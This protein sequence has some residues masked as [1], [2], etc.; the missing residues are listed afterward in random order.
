MDVHSPLP[1]ELFPTRP[2]VD[3][4]VEGLAGADAADTLLGYYSAG[5]RRADDH[6][7]A[8]LALLE[9]AGRLEETWVILTADHGEELNEHGMMLSHGQ[10]LYR[11]L[12]WVPLVI[13]LPGALAAGSVPAGPVSHIDLLP[14]LLETAGASVP[15]G[16]GHSLA[17]LLRGEETPATNGHRAAFSEL[18]KRMLY[19]R[20]V[21]T[22]EHHFIETFHISKTP[23]ATLAD[24]G[25]GISVEVK[26]QVLG[27][28]DFLPTKV[29]VGIPGADKLLGLVEAVDIAGGTLT[30][31]GCAVRVDAG[32]ELVG[33][34]KAPF[35]LAD[36]TAGERV[37]VT[38]D[39]EPGG[40]RRARA[41]MWRKAGGESKLEGPVEAI[42]ATGPEGTLAIRVL[43]W[44]VRV[45]PAQ[46]RLVHREDSSRKLR[47]QDV[48]AMVAAGDWIARE[49]E[50][51]RYPTDPAEAVNLADD[52]VGVVDALEQ[53]LAGWAE[54]IAGFQAP[55]EPVEIDLD[56]IEQLRK[57]GYLA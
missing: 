28:D 6:V 19:S 43:G 23:P 14:T 53:R 56:T 9:E 24:L 25:P 29:T 22:A 15:P 12:V 17:P 47:R 21:T 8:V 46:V 44:W 39:P 31:L 20:S 37:N 48:L 42:D 49:R 7:G 50:L 38:L 33:L 52:E 27:A 34:D 36:L 30:V 5:V 11:Q 54:S 32:T 51:Y 3:R 4:G 2:M 13:R 16:P 35:A 55:G 40:V 18:V 57:L 41:V 10:S 1:Q 26:G 45:D